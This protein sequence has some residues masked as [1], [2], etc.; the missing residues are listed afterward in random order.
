MVA[1]EVRWQVRLLLRNPL[2]GVLVVALPVLLLPLVHALNPHAMVRLP[3]TPL[4]RSKSFG[5]GF[6]TEG[7]LPPGPVAAFDQ[8]LVPVLI[9]FGVAAGCFANLAIGV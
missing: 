9:A 3:G 8:Y 7:A 4:P 2:A 1:R 6:G 5:I